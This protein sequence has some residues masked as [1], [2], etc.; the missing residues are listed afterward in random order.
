V[1]LEEAQSRIRTMSNGTTRDSSPSPVNGHCP[2]AS[3]PPS[4]DYSFPKL[5]VGS[6]LI[7]LRFAAW[8]T[9]YSFDL[10]RRNKLEKIGGNRESSE[11]KVRDILPRSTLRSFFREGG[12]GVIHELVWTFSEG[13]FHLLLCWPSTLTGADYH[14]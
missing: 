1:T 11:E 13:P 4:E 12:A 5:V 9:A 3:P 14:R 2:L 7:S 10:K 8:R 6:R